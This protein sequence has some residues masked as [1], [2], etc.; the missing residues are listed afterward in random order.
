MRT[1]KELRAL[2]D[3]CPDEALV[4]MMSD[5]EGNETKWFETIGQ[6]WFIK[7]RWG[8]RGSDEHESGAV[9]VLVLW[10]GYGEP[11]DE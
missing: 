4:A 9:P 7:G 2:L 6:D 8:W 11:F 5:E 10:P 1:V 3:R